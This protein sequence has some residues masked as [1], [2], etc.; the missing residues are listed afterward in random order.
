MYHALG[1]SVGVI[2]HDQAYLYDPDFT[3]EE[4]GDERLEHFRPVPRK[5]AYAADVTYGTNNEF[6][7]DY[8]RD[9]MAQRLADQVQ[10]EHHFAIV[11]EADSFMIDEARTPL[12]ISPLTPNDPSTT[13]FP[14]GPLL[15]RTRLSSGLKN[16]NRNADD[17]GV[18]AIERSWE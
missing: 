12:I 11:D 15:P 16:S 5:D 8:L 9:N 10:R 4:R 13:S 6:G 3:G 14:D 17:L 18:K 2:I 1:V 7:F